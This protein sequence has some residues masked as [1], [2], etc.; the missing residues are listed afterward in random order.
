VNDERPTAERLRR[1]QPAHQR[2]DDPLALACGN[3]QDVPGAA[4]VDDQDGQGSALVEIS[5]PG[6]LIHSRVQQD[7]G[8]EFVRKAADQYRCSDDR[9]RRL[10]ETTASAEGDKCQQRAQRQQERHHKGEQPRSRLR[11][12]MPCG[13]CEDLLRGAIQ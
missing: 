10:V 4:E 8:A 1:P 12:R 2:G 11:Q 13:R 7:L 3:H 6:P 5:A 9:Y